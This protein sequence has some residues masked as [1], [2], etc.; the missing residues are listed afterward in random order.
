MA[1]VLYN[2]ICKNRTG[3]S[4]S[5]FLCGLRNRLQY[6]SGIRGGSGSRSLYFG[7]RK[8]FLAIYPM[9]VYDDNC[10]IPHGGT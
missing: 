2:Y 7:M 1:E 4:W 8:I 6:V 10:R 5:V 9:W 3:S